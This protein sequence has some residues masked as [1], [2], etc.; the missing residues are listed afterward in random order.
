MDNNN[1]KSKQMKNRVFIIA[2]IYACIL[3]FCSCEYKWEKYDELVGE[4]T[5]NYSFLKG[6]KLIFYADGTCS[7]ENVPTKEIDPWGNIDYSLFW[8]KARGNERFQK[9]MASMDKWNFQ[10]YWKI[11]EDTLY[12]KSEP[13][14]RYRVQISPH[15]EILGTEQERDSFMNNSNADDV[16]WVEMDAWAITYF[17]PARLQYL[18]FYTRDPDNDY[19]FFK[20]K[21]KN[22]I[23][24][25]LF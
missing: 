12:Y 18:S 23:Y 24:K 22:I 25:W 6:S 21:K 11:K 2:S 13:Y 14:Y 5:S 20:R 10:G 4:W 9:R 3:L 16:F 19:C 1:Q 17:P 15:K 7:V 8:W